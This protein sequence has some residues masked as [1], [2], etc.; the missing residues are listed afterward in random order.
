MKKELFL[1]CA[2]CGTTTKVDLTPLTAKR[3]F[4]LI[5]KEASEEE[6]MEEIYR[7]HPETVG[8]VS[9]ECNIEIIFICENG[10]GMT[11]V[12]YPLYE[13]CHEYECDSE[14]VN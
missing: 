9:E 8:L 7:Q 12:P 6:I 14:Y 10:S 11:I 2:C 13:E 4:K 1:R 3:I 5:Q